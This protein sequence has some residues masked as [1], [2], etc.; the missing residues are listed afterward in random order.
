MQIKIKTLTGRSLSLDF[1]PTATVRLRSFAH[2]S[3]K[4]LFLSLTTV[5]S[6]PTHVPL[7]T[8]GAQFKQVKEA[9]QEREGIDKSQ[10]CVL[11]SA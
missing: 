6:S 8:P 11:G 5:L 3:V 10:M 2:L 7:H 1:E 4:K 9:L